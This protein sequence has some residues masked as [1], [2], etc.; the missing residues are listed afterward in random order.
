MRAGCVGGGEF[1]RRVALRLVLAGLCAAPLAIGA[2]SLGAAQAHE[3]EGDGAEVPIGTF[4][5][6]P[7]EAVL[8]HDGFSIIEPPAGV[9]ERLRDA[10][11]DGSGRWF[12]QGWDAPRSREVSAEDLY[13]DAKAALDQGRRDDAQR[14]FE[15]LIAEAPDSPRVAN[16]RQYLGQIYRSVG[17]ASSAARGEAGEPSGDEALPWQRSG[18]ASSDARTGVAGV[19]PPVPRSALYQAR[20]AP[21]VDSEFLSDAGDRVFF[22]AGSANLG[23]R[24]RS[25]IQ[26]QA[27]FLMR[28]PDLYAAIEGHADD[29]AMSDIE[30]LRIS[31]E[32][33][34]VVRD[35]LVAEGV[36][37]ARLMAYGRG[38][39][40]RVSDCPTPECLAQ[41]RR[42]V[43]VLLS[44]RVGDAVAPS[45]RAQGGAP[46]ASDV[47]PTQ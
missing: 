7:R 45:R 42:A 25:V 47:W 41:N 19:S 24:A 4:T 44:R 6:G 1:V 3:P 29:G 15:R 31:E 12:F 14:L 43:T 33:A 34:A 11:D 46:S 32:R 18:T 8:P 23:A 9:P 37:A 40:E 22:G 10:T 35:R 27:R 16:A 13:R 21:V 5:L 28:Y 39:E 38:R 36:D 17:T 20:V 26:A 2:A 30:T